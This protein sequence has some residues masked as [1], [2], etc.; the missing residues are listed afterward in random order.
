M[1]LI[2]NMYIFMIIVQTRFK[3]SGQHYFMASANKLL[4]LYLVRE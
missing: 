2:F 1:I 3:A 4:L